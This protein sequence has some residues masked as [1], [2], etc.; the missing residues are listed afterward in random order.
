MKVAKMVA[1]KAT[2]MVVSSVE[3]W[4]ALRVDLLVGLMASQ[5]VAALV[6]HSVV[7]MVAPTESES[8]ESLVGQW[9]CLLSELK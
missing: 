9:V 4:V 2:Q 7:K 1:K 8:G 5:K 3:K 6:E